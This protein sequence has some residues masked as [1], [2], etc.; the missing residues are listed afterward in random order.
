MRLFRHYLDRQRQPPAFLDNLPVR[1]VYLFAEKSYRPTG[2]FDGELILFRATEGVG[3]DEPYIQ[4]YRDPL[5]GWGQR[6]SQGVRAYDVPGGHSS[7]LQEP[8]AEVLACQMQT[9]IDEVLSND[10]ADRHAAAQVVS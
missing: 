6:A 9:I 7:M 5:F 8:N 2:V 10:R 1:T 3:N 4:R